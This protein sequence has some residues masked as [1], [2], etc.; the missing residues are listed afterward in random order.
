MVAPFPTKEQVLGAL[1]SHYGDIHSKM[2]RL[3]FAHKSLGK[4]PSHGVTREH[5]LHLVN[6]HYRIIKSVKD[7]ETEVMKEKS[8]NKR[9]STPWAITNNWYYLYNP[10]KMFP[11]HE[12]CNICI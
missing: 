10:G 3:I 4:I 6:G 8:W 9:I 1:G 5:L 11:D 7:L 2:G 12:Q